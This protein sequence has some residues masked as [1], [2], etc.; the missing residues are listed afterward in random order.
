MILGYS[1]DF[2]EFKCCITPI[3]TCITSLVF[4]NDY[5]GKPVPNHHRIMQWMN[6][7]SDVKIDF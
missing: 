5:R 1:Y 4:I 6:K 7:I 2:G 3:S